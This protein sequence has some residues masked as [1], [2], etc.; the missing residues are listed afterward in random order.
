MKHLPN[1][2]CGNNGRNG[3]ALKYRK[4]LVTKQSFLCNNLIYHPMSYNRY[5]KSLL[6]LLLRWWG[7]LLASLGVNVHKK[8]QNHEKQRKIPGSSRFV[9]ERA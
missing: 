2:V 9:A 1:F 3:R 6:T 5:W 7:G 8:I 4:Q